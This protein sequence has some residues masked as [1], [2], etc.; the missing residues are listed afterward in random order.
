MR[1]E[2]ARMPADDLNLVQWL[3]AQPG[4]VEHTVH[5]KREG[6]VLRV[7]LMMMQDMRGSQPLPDLSRACD[8]LGYS[9]F[10]VWEED[11]CDSM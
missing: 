11:T 8:S 7:W 4:V 3:R 2:Y 1:A 9:P 6:R 5:V 10:V